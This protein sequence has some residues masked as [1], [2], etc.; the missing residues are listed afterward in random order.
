MEY[1][2]SDSLLKGLVSLLR[3]AKENLIRK[4][5]IL[6][7]K[8]TYFDKSQSQHSSKYCYNSY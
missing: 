4:P 2:V 8:K 6:D 5:E 7:G 1:E 3:P